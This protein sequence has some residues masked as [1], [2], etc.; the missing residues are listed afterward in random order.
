MTVLT[1]ADRDA[2]SAEASSTRAVA[3]G[4]TSR[5][6]RGSMMKAAVYNSYGPPGVVR[7]AEVPKPQ[8]KDNEVLVRIHASTVTSGDWRARSL[9]MPAGFGILGR[10]VFG[11]LKPRQPILGT[12]LA[13]VVEATGRSVTR[14]RPG[15][16]VVAFPGGRFGSHAEYRTMAE[17]GAIAFKPANLSFAEAASLFF[18]STTALPFLRD[19]A[20][21][22]R[23]EK[24][25]VVGASGAVGTA[26]VQIARHLGAA[27]T[28]VTSTGNVELVRSLGAEKVID[29]TREDFATT[30]ET[31][32]VIVDTTS[33]APYSRC[34]AVLNPGGRLVVVN[35]SFAQALGIGAPSRASG[36]RVITG[37][38]PITPDDVL[39][40]AEMAAA[41]DLVPVI[42]R[43]YPLEQVADAHAYVDTGRKR[44]SVVL[45]V[46]PADEG[47][48]SDHRPG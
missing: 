20:R 33:T 18:G 22:K 40:I 42:D 11:I 15:D 31:W 25:L 5:P 48:R 47:K 32:D 30:G 4:F 10:L 43:T 36:K 46:I 19:K 14:F 6:G 41:G 23:G 8:P 28:G 21:L 37:V 1:H 13:G 17:D 16:E 39:Y 34:A 12:E 2:A 27:V 9:K 24:V 45:M 26:L 3:A 7:I 35:G 44:G 38:A 29:Y